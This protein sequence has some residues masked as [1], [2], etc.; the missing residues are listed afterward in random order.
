M[1]QIP[2]LRDRRRLGEETGQREA[3][4]KGQPAPAVEKTPDADVPHLHALEIARGSIIEPARE[5]TASA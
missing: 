2:I 1:R 5:K 3:D 4:A